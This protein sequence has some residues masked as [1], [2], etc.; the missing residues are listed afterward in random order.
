MKMKKVIA[1]MLTSIMALTTVVGCSKEEATSTASTASKA[2]T[3]TTEV[4]KVEDIVLKFTYKQ[5][6]ANDPLEKFFTERKIIEQFEAENPGVKIQ[7]TPITSQEG[8]YATMLALQLSSEKTAPDIFMEDT[9]MTATDAASGYL[10]CLDDYL[11]AWDDWDHYLE[12]TKDAVKGTDGKSYGI[13]I[14]T[15][16][17]GIWYSY[18]VFKAAGIATPWQ[19]KTWEDVLDAARKIKALGDEITPFHMTVGSVN[20]EGVTMQT[21]QMLLYGTG[22]TMYENGKWLVESQSILDTFTFI[23]TTYNAEKLGSSLDI[24]LS[25]EGSAIINT[26]L[27]PNAKIGMRLDTSTIAGNWASTGAAPIENVEE[28]IGFASMPTQNGGD[29]ATITMCGGWSWAISEYSKNKD[30]AFKFLAFCGNQENATWRSLYDGRMSPRD[31]STAIAEYA[32]RAYIKEMTGHMA[33]AYVRPKNESYAMV[34][35]QVQ[36]LIEELASG[37]ITAAQAAEQYK[38]RITNVVGEENTFKK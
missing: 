4:A 22:D 31:D 11:A 24:A 2:G 26:E 34:S 9:Y 38:A 14:S 32:S 18:E 3:K 29:P 5:A 19:P 7:L 33:N 8:D 16:S 1:L 20:G 12:G 27:F 21:F 10:A 36:A 30:M 15:D 13:P 25:S 37:S 23:D 6:S 35:T 17:R 28:V